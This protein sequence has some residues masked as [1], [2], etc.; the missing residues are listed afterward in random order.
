MVQNLQ[1]KIINQKNPISSL[2]ISPPRFVSLG[3]PKWMLW[4][5]GNFDEIKEHK[6]GGQVLYFDFLQKVKIQDLTLISTN[7]TIDIDW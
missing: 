1:G 5:C 4:E 2:P 3:S 6:S 7:H